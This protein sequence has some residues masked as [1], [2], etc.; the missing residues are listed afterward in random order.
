MR[1]KSILLLL[2][3]LGCGLVASIG[4]TQVMATRDTAATTSTETETIFVAMKDIAMGDPITAQMVKLEPW[5]KD[6]VPAGAISKLEDLEG[7]KPRGPIPA[8]SPIV[9]KHLVGKGLNESGPGNIIPAGFRVAPVKVDPVMGNAN[10]LRPSDRVD[11]LVHVKQDPS[12]GIPRTCTRTIL[13]DIKVFAV[14]DQFDVSATSGEKS[15]VAK[16]IWLLV[17]PEQAEKVTL[18][19]ELGQVRLVMRSPVDKEQRKLDGE[20]P[21]GLLEGLVAAEPPAAQPS[22]EPPPVVEPPPAQ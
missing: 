20:D 2:L 14:N 17:T 12:K 11:V 7:R 22:P 1:A 19:A 5:P 4:I 16:T 6:K 15:V 13:Q 3:A 18:A 21:S 9:E 10:M 8:G